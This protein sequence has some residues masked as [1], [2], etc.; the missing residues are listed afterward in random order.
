MLWDRPVRLWLVKVTAYLA[1][2]SFGDQCSAIPLVWWW[3]SEFVRTRPK[4]AH[5]A[6]GAS[7][8]LRCTGA[9]QR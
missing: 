1:V 2:A 8:A 5:D 9:Q 3:A 4:R 6:H 7:L